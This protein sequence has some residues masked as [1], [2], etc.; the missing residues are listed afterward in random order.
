MIEHNRKS[1]CDWT[2]LLGDL[3]FDAMQ[4]EECA[5]K[6][7]ISSADWRNAMLKCIDRIGRYAELLQRYVVC[8]GCGRPEIHKMCPAWGT[9][10]YMSGKLYTAEDEAEF[11]EQHRKAMMEVGNSKEA[12][13]RA[14]WELGILK[15][16]ID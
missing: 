13:E 6:A 14:D 9:P 12:N 1:N 15:N 10:F 11:G 16:K 2:D 5:R 3:W 7:D 8:K 4:V